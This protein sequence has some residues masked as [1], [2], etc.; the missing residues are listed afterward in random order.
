MVD[1]VIYLVATKTKI[2]TTDLAMTHTN[3]RT[4]GNITSACFCSVCP[5][6]KLADMVPLLPQWQGR[7][8]A[9]ENT[10][11][12]FQVPVVGTQ[13]YSNIGPQNMGPG[14]PYHLA[15]LTPLMDMLGSTLHSMW[16][17]WSGQ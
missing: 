16:R 15:W 9:Q 5:A 1:C 12:F 6:V 8:V 10:E 2:D 14:D 17:S 13:G 7:E 4:R 11:T 3:T